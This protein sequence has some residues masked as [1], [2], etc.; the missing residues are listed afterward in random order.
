MNAAHAQEE[1]LWHPVTR[2]RSIK[3]MRRLHFLIANFSQDAWFFRMY[4]SNFNSSKASS[5]MMSPPGTRM[6]PAC[7][8]DLKLIWLAP[9]VTALSSQT[10]Q[11]KMG[12]TRSVTPYIHGTGCLCPKLQFC[13]TFAHDRLSRYRSSLNLANNKRMIP[14]GLP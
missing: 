13:S 7:L 3:R 2:T 11:T 1:V 6:A 8:E 4:C 12:S 10:C 5:V 14:F 9:C